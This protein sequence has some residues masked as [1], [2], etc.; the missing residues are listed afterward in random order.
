M[1]YWSYGVMVSHTKRQSSQPIKGNTMN[2]KFDNLQL[3]ISQIVK[4]GFEGADPE[5]P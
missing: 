3:S 2:T 1:E 4:Y 5:G